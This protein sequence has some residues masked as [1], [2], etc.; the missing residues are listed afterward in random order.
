MRGRRSA[1]LAVLAAFAL[2]ATA[3]GGGGT[4]AKKVEIFG[5]FI[6]TE[7]SAT[8]TLIQDKINTPDNI[9]ATYTGSDSFETQIK[10]RVDGGNPPDVAIYPQPTSIV[11]LAKAGKVQSL[12]DMGFDMTAMEQKYGSYL[13]SLGEYNGKHYAI[14]TNTN[15]K[16]LIWYPKKAW[17]A[18]GYQVP[19]TWADL[20]T[21]SAQV[22]TDQ[23]ATAPWCI[24]M[25]SDAATGWPGTDWIEDIVLHTYGPDV[26]DK[27]VSHEIKFESPQIKH[28]FE[29]FGQVLF[30]QGWVLGGAAQTP[31]INYKDAPAP[32][33][34]TP[35]GCMLHRQGSFIPTFFPAGLTGNVDYAV[36]PFPPIEGGT[37][38]AEI[39]GDFMTIFNNKPEVKTFIDGYTSKDFMCT[40][41]STEGLQRIAPNTDVGPDCYSDP[42]VKTEAGAIVNAIKNGSARF[43]ASDAMPSAVGSGSFWTGMVDFATNGMSDLDT[44]LKQID[45]SWPSS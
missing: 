31:S 40:R 19:Q 17:D 3:C 1:L 45:D 30:T 37:G 27:W 13:L 38:G 21:L 10:V 18:A 26:Y 15:I 11:E 4:A 29:L 34:N 36:F 14:P 22:L 43:D 39:G 12:E 41:G 6:G 33:F 32:M 35:P 25:G 28:A 9:D 20:M 44:I 42:I 16:S 8:Q 5:A 24:G 2:V 7:Q 23:T